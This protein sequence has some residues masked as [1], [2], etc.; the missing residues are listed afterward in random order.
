MKAIYKKE[1]RSYFVNPIGY[2][3]LGVF[4]AFSAFLCCYTT[5]IAGSY[6][7][8]N[9]YSNLILSFIVLIP[10]L[11]MRLFAEERKMK[12]EQLL[13]TSPVSLTG[14]VLGKYFA[15][16][17]VFAG[18][19]L[20]SC[21]NLIPL[22]VIGAAERN[23]TSSQMRQIGP[24][25]GEI[26]GSLIAVLLLGAALI[27]LGTLISALTE[28]QLSAAV[29]TVGAIS[30]MLGASLLGRMSD[31]DGQPILAVAFRSILDWISVFSRF[32]LFST[33]IFDYAALIYYVSLS[34][35]F[36]FLTVRLYERRR[37][38]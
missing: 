32:S 28:N 19:I 7:T 30:L 13:L 22:Y 21:V 15:A 27:A 8:A 23:G 4:L 3:Y 34:F 12:T 31:A 37:I 11:T 9:Y 25:S 26:F 14:M 6:S 29:V 10:L 18:G 2:I 5:L 38:G 24:V 20:V 36:L 1:L 16:L 33:G 35:L 17:T